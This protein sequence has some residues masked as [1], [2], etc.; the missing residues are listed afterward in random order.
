MKLS[1]Y[2]RMWC[3]ELYFHNYSWTLHMMV[4]VCLFDVW[5]PGRMADVSAV[6]VLQSCS[7]FHTGYCF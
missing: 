5:K 4:S 6:S 1:M 3:S 2:S 7:P